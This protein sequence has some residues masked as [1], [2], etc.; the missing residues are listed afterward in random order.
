MG[1]GTIGIVYRHSSFVYRLSSIVYRLSSFMY[2]K[3]SSYAKQTIP[4]TTINEKRP[5]INDQQ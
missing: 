4:I 2:K 1:I 5:T 3:Q